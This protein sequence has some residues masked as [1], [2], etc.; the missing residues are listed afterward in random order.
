MGISLIGTYTHKSQLFEVVR[1][2]GCCLERKLVHLLD[3]Y[4]SAALKQGLVVGNHHGLSQFSAAL[5]Q[6]GFNLL[7]LCVCLGFGGLQLPDC[8]EIPEAFLV[9]AQLLEALRPSV[10]GLGVLI[11]VLER[12]RGIIQ[13]LD[14]FLN[15]EV[16]HRPVGQNN[17][18]QLLLLV[19]HVL[20]VRAFFL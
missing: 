15:L 20:E 11:V 3:F 6:K 8:L 18:S 17:A 1:C 9:L 19:G 14:G 13:G 12:F 10:V 2:G 4:P 16:G 7:Y 5:G